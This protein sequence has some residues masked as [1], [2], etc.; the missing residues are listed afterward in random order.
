VRVIVPDPELHC[1]DPDLRSMDQNYGSGSE[2]FTLGLQIIIKAVDVN[3]LGKH[4]TE[5]L[6]SV[7]G[8]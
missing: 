8:V 5:K 2:S 7:A 4:F 3:V 6:S 1:P